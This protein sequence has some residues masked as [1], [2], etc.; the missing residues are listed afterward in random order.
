[1]TALPVGLAAALTAAGQ[2]D[3]EWGDL[4][5]ELRLFMEQQQTDLHNA[6][7]LALNLLRLDRV[8]TGVDLIDREI[9]LRVVL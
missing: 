8:G 1:M 9:T 2:T 6:R 7:L 3:S 5:G 4:A